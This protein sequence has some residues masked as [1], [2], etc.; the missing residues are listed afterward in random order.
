MAATSSLSVASVSP[1]VIDVGS[2]ACKVG[3]ANWTEPRTTHKYHTTNDVKYPVER[4]QITD[5]ENIVVLLREAFDILKTPAFA[6]PVMLTDS[7]ANTKQSRETIT[8]KMFE[9]FS[10]PAFYL[11]M[12]NPLVS[13]ALEKPESCISLECGDGITSVVCIFQGLGVLLEQAAYICV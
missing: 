7:P 6:Q 4:G 12:S 8:S 5:W 9:T 1:V 3:F 11:G 10:V 13:Y 2:A